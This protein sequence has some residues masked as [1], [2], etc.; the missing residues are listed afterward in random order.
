M[1]YQHLQL[2]SNPDKYFETGA[3]RV[4]RGPMLRVIS[5]RMPEILLPE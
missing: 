4:E 3:E 2:R 5:R 1:K